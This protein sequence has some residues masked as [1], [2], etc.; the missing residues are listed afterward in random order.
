MNLRAPFFLR[1]ALILAVLAGSTARAQD[2]GGTPRPRAQ[3]LAGESRLISHGDVELLTYE[4]EA[5]VAKLDSLLA[6]NV[7]APSQPG[8]FTMNFFRSTVDG[9]V[10]PYGFFLPRDY[11]PD[12]KFPLLIQIHGIGPK[13]LA[14]RRTQWR[15]MG[16]KEWIDT[17]LPVIVAQPLGRGNTFYQGMGET[18]VLEVVADVSRRYS[19]DPARIYIMGHSMG[20]A[21]SWF[22]GLRHP[23]RFGSITPID[24][25]LGFRDAVESPDSSSA[26]MLPQIATFRPDNYF[27]NARNIPVFLK[28]AGAGIQGKSTRYSDGIVAE[29]GFAT[30]E[31]FPG[32]PHHFA[33]QISYAVFESA[34]VLRPIPAAPREVKFFTTNLRYD[35]AYWVTL[36]RLEQSPAETRVSAVYDDGLPP[37]PPPGRR[38]PPREPEPPRPPT[39]SVTTK[40]V[41]GLTLRLHDAGVVAGKVPPL[42]IDGTTLT[43]P[44]DAAVVHVVKSAGVWQLAST[45]AS[46]GKR[47]GL[48]GPIGDAFTAKFLAV[49]GEGDLPL[50]RAELDA[51][52]NPPSQLV[53]QAEFPLK[54]AARVTADDLANSNLILFGTPKTNP[55]LARLAP[56]LPAGLFAE[57]EQGR[58]ALIV[59]VYPKP[60]KTPIVYV[61]CLDWT[62]VSVRCWS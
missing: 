44:A 28:N 1:V 25:A 43:L 20:G 17:N 18:D 13:N 51:V 60:L 7:A 62:R 49:Y 59:F 55:V 15:G 37:P 52:R 12:A 5:D 4:T 30:M 24:A 6:A 31:S 2:P 39:L 22:V 38:G 21:G 9:S 27:P 26:W 46:S 53:I 35:R 48:Q 19:V 32:M 56:K 54:A 42:T 3:P 36:D 34:A 11:R 61:C 23:D 33:P 8:E 47:H 41:D 57:V 50:A 16:T 45:P 40:N 10:Q 58:R 29:G 14:G